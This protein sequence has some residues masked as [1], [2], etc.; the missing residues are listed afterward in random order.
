MEELSTINRRKFLK[1]SGILLGGAS[2]AAMPLNAFANKQ[3][4]RLTILHT[5]DWHSRI[6]SFDATDKNYP[7]QGG[8]ERRAALI[9]KIR[10]EE[11]NVLLLD[12]GD[13]FQGTPY[14]NFYGGELEYKLMSQMKYDC[15]TLGNH[16]FDN[17]IEGLF[18]QMPNASFDFVNCNYQ[19]SGTLLEN[20]V[21]PYK[22]YKRGGIKIGVTG[23]GIE[24]E[25]LVP[26]KLYGKIKYLDPLENLNKVATFLKEEKKC[27]LVI[28]LSHLG[29][30]YEGAKISDVSIAPLSKHVDLILGGHTHTFLKEPTI[31][32]NAQQKEVIINQVGWAGLHLGRIDYTF[33]SLL[34]NK[35]M[36]TFQNVDIVDTNI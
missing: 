23:V 12:A 20:K 4:T 28:C 1:Q 27:D 6:D 18:K 9:K 17:G 35:F 29:Y 26:A 13:I 2:L 31:L 3:E 25:G 21:L 11:E 8:A 36:H 19:F 33:S 24:L 10:Q 5:N 34:N 7:G 15:V 32:K 16:D 22:I 30:K 14:F